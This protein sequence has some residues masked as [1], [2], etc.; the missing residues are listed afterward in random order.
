MVELAADVANALVAEEDV[1]EDVER[2]VAANE[3]DARAAAVGGR[4]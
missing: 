4:M 1:I 3:G 2:A